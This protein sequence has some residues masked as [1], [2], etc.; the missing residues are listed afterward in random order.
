M[1][2]Y[3]DFLSFSSY[4]PESVRIALGHDW[5]AIFRHWRRMARFQKRM[6]KKRHARRRTPWLA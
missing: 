1:R 5:Q 2:K 3:Y 4:S 6:A